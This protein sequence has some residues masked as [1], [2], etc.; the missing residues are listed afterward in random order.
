MANKPANNFTLLANVKS[1][2]LILEFIR[3]SEASLRALSFTE[4]GFRHATL[5]SDR[6]RNI[7]QD[8]GFSAKEAEL[9][10]IAGFCHD[11][12]NFVG[13]T[14]HHYWGSILFSQIFSSEFS[15]ADLARIMQAIA[16]HDKEDMRFTNPTSALVVLADKSDV[17][18][19]RVFADQ[20]NDIETDIHDRVNYATTDARLK[21]NKNSKKIIL[22]IKIDTKFVPIMEYFEIFTGRMTYC[23]TAAEFL[24]YEFGLTINNF[25]L[26]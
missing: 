25:K 16:N 8:M 21:V 15:P 5:V 19:K 14:D 2:P 17:S 3:E 10:A 11:M 24:G 7:A 1:N 26:L 12:G 9:A 18:R 23:R 13:R 4:H 22:T 20:I 6:A